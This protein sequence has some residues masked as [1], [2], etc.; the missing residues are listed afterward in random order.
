MDVSTGHSCAGAHRSLRSRPSCPVPGTRTTRRWLHCR[1]KPDDHTRQW[2]SIA[3]STDQPNKGSRRKAG[4]LGMSMSAGTRAEPFST[5]AGWL[6]ARASAQR[7]AARSP[8]PR[9]ATATHC[10]SARPRTPSAVSAPCSSCGG[11]SWRLQPLTGT[12]PRPGAVGRSESARRPR[13]ACW[14][15]ARR[16]LTGDGT[17]ASMCNNGVSWSLIRMQV[18]PATRFDGRI[19]RRTR[20]GR[21]RRRRVGP[22]IGHRHAGAAVCCTPCDG[23]W[24]VG[25][26]NN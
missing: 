1:A 16:Y 21:A 4:P 12:G 19:D 17:A 14:C 5:T 13:D 8:L 20:S 15:T 3:F 25:S 18:T 24:R 10:P 23:V 6:G 26:A 9:R 2:W 7:S 22:V 11:C